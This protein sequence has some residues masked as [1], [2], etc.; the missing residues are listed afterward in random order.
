MKSIVIRWSFWPNV[1]TALQCP[2]IVM[3]CCLLLSELRVYCDKTTEVRIAQ[4]S[5]K[6]SVR[7]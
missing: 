4:F 1:A 7:S 6:S 5:H 3:I 2:D